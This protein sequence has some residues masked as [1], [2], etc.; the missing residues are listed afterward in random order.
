MW[1]QSRTIKRVPYYF[2]FSAPC[3][4]A[5][6]QGSSEAIDRTVELL[7]WSS[8]RI[9][10]CIRSQD[11]VYSRTTPINMTS[12]LFYHVQ[13]VGFLRRWVID[14]LE[15]FLFLVAARWIS[16]CF[17]CV[18]CNTEKYNVRSTSYEAQNTIF[19]RSS[20][21]GHYWALFLH[22]ALQPQQSQYRRCQ[23]VRSPINIK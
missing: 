11:R 13:C 2:T 1:L 19:I 22:C 5:R 8:S 23:V 3:L 9:V 20:C 16:D 6:S 4:L 12:F 17:I 18:R 14:S 21:K 15:M 10:R 7:P